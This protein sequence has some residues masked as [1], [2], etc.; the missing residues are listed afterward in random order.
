M[1]GVATAVCWRSGIEAKCFMGFLR[2]LWFWI[3]PVLLQDSASPA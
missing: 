1:A 2:T 3:N